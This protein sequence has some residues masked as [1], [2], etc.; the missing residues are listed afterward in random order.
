MGK[1]LEGQNRKDPRKVTARRRGAV[2]GYVKHLLQK[3]GVASSW[4]EVGGSVDSAPH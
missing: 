4:E 2:D 3:Y 1:V